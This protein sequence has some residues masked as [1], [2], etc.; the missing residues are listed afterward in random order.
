VKDLNW[1]DSRNEIDVSD[2]DA[3][4]KKYAQ[5]L[6]DGS[7][8]GTVLSESAAYAELLSCYDNN[9]IKAWGAKCRAASGDGFWFDGVVTSLTLAAPLEGAAE[10]SFT[11]RPTGAVTRVAA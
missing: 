3:T 9:T 5:G 11:I 6:S 7:L 8:T 4:Y 2:R 10:W 1:S